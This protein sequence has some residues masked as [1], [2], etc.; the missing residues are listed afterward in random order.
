MTE[1]QPDDRSLAEDAADAVK[2]EAKNWLRSV[3]VGGVF[4]ALALGG[5]GLHHFGTHG[6]MIGLAAGAIVGAL[7]GWFLYLHLWVSTVLLAT[8]VL[9]SCGDPGG[10]PTRDWLTEQPELGASA[11]TVE[12]EFGAPTERDRELI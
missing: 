8:C 10:P 7:A 3:V 4:G 6:L 9:T 12:A 11:D 5:F 1:P 2:G